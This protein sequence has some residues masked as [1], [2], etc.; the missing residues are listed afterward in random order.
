M[1]GAGDV[2]PAAAIAVCFG[3]PRFLVEAVLE[4]QVPDRKLAGL[5][6]VRVV[7]VAGEHHRLLDAN[8][9]RPPSRADDGRFVGR[10]SIVPW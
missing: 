10:A 6:S 1:Q 4:F 8:N 7:E 5:H 9:Y 2:E 3:I